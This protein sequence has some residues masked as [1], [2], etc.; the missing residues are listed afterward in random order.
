MTVATSAPTPSYPKAR[1]I[2]FR[3]DG[4]DS[5]KKYFIAGDMVFSHFIA[6][7]SGAFPA[8]EESFIRSVRRC[9]DRITDPD[10]RKRVAG[11][12]GQEAS[13]GA[14]HRNLNE[15]LVAHGYPVAWADTP[16]LR[17]WLRAFEESVPPVVHLAAVASAEHVTAL[18]SERSL[19][20]TEIQSIPAEPEYWNIMNWHT[21]E[22][23]EHKSVVFDVFRAMGGSETTRIGVTAVMTAVALPGAFAA[24]AISIALDPVANR[25]PV[26]LTREAY[27]LFRG[28]IF[29]GLTRDLAKYLR[30]GFHPD[31]H[32]TAELLEHWQQELFGPHGALVDH[33]K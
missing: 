20:S 31:D 10:L 8:A 32:D 25:R 4:P 5:D 7:L 26:R 30:P 33:L 14:Q 3:F 18:L 29:R 11:F 24:L 12:I 9:S 6:T 17:A 28:P 21:L 23:I 16:A 2:E 13:H 1:R 22:E 15:K 27:R 19:S